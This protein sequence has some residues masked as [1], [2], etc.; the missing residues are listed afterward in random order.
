MA[1]GWGIVSLG[2]HPNNKMAPAINAARDTTLAAVYSRD[3]EQAREFAQRHGAGA[4]YDSYE[5]FLKDPN[6]DVV[7]VASPNSLHEQHTVSAA[8]AGKHVLCEKPMAITLEACQNM[9]DT[10]AREDV[11]LGIAFHARHHP[12]HQ[13]A[14][15]LVQSGVAGTV[16][17]AQ[18][19]WGNGQRGLTAPP[20]RIGRE[21]WWEQPEMVGAGTFMGNGV[22]ASDLLRYVLGQEVVELT[23]MTDG[24]TGA[25][26]LEHLATL[27]LRFQ[28]GSMGMVY[29]TRKIPDPRSD[30]VVYGSHGRVAV[31]GSVGVV[32]QGTLEVISETLNTSQTYESPDPIALYTNMVEAFNKSVQEGTEPNASGW[33]GFKVVQIT[34]GM[35]ESARTG[36]LVKLH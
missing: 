17:L 6:L 35:L 4:A 3:I 26:P 34:L 25:Q 1:F 24:Q 22:H 21:K 5:D 20:P 13:E 16:A 36:R 31:Y 19:Q 23:A 8:R 9:I 2:R 18:A 27:L 12:G 10:C 28:D 30:L 14:R 33:D 15:R 32:L 7:Y 11:K 29:S